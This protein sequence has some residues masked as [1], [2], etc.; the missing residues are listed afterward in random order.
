MKALALYSLA[1]MN[2][3]N[4]Q[5]QISTPNIFKEDFTSLYKIYAGFEKGR[6]GSILSVDIIDG[7]L[8][9]DER[10]FLKASYLIEKNIWY[11]EVEIIPNQQMNTYLKINQEFPQMNSIFIKVSKKGQTVGYQ[12][13]DLEGN[14]LSIPNAIPTVPETYEVSL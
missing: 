10:M 3:M 2:S 6:D 5:T 7:Y 1:M 13:I 14:I 11:A 12:W 9:S 8:K 4:T